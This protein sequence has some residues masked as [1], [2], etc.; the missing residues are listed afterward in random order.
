[1]MLFL[2]GGQGVQ[3]DG[4]HADPAGIQGVQPSEILTG[5]DMLHVL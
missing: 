3:F 1:M 4:A 5:Q 2:L